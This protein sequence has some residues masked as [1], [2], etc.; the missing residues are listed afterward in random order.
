MPEGTRGVTWRCTFRDP[1]RTL[2][3]R[4]VDALLGTMLSAL[5]EQ[6]GVHRRQT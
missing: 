6:L 5:E 3:E 4:E 1:A 2:T